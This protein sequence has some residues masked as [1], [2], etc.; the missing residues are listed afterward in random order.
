MSAEPVD[1]REPG[2]N[3][4]GTGHWWQQRVSAIALVPL[5][6]WF[7]LALAS[8]SVADRS[9]VL[10]WIRSG[11]NGLWLVALVLAAAQHSYLGTRV[12]FEDYVSNLKGRVGTVVMLQFLHMVM[13]GAGIYAVLRVA[14]GV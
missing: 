8:V 13:A 10:Q 3:G 11:M 6:V 12:I 2:P 4:H 14:L 7:V 5:L 9:S 1:R